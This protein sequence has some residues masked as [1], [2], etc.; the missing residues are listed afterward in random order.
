MIY[1][2]YNFSKLITFWPSYHI[3]QLTGI[4]SGL[5]SNRFVCFQNQAVLFFSSQQTGL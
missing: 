1:K 3:T 2:N 5:E 4:S